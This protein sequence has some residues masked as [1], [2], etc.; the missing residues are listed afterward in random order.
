MAVV[1]LGCAVSIF[2]RFTLYSCVYFLCFKYKL[3]NLNLGPF[4]KYDYTPAGNLYFMYI[5][6][7]L[8]LNADH[9]KPLSKLTKFKIIIVG[10]NVFLSFKT[11]FRYNILKLFAHYFNVGNA[12]F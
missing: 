4:M 1:E 6:F 5:I 3:A 2:D 9:S 8:F 7:V 12:K 11:F 10:N